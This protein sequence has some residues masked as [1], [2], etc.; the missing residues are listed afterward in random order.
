LATG[1]VTN[2]FTQFYLRQNL[3]DNRFQYARAPAISV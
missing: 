2:G 3:A 1:V